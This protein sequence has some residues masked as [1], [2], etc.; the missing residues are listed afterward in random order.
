MTGVQRGALI[1]IC[2]MSFAPGLLVQFHADRGPDLVAGRAYAVHGVPA[3]GRG[4]RNAK[5][6]MEILPKPYLDI[7]TAFA[8][9][10]ELLG[11]A[12]PF[13]LWMITRTSGN[14]WIVLQSRDRAYDVSAGKVFKWTDS[15]CSRMVKGLGP[16]Y[17]PSSEEIPAYRDAPI[18]KQVHIGSYLGT[19]IRMADGSLFGTLCAISPQPKELPELTPFQHKLVEAV[20]RTLATLIENK[21]KADSL[22]RELD[23][24]QEVSLT[25][26]LTGLA[27]RRG[28]ATALGL[29]EARSGQLGGNAAIFMI[30]LDGLKAVNDTLGHAAGDA[31][32]VKTAAVLRRMVR[33]SDTVARLGGDEFGILLAG[34]EG[35]EIEDFATRLREVLEAADVQASI[36]HT[37]RRE[38]GSLEAA[39]AA[40]D[41]LM[42][43]QKQ[44]RKGAAIPGR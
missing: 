18:G 5:A 20:T 30:D 2:R 1:R 28:W 43:A 39:S 35:L 24:E 21:M 7:R 6:M 12:I 3:G 32:I 19:P 9:Y 38:A 17:A 33:G 8:A 10:L 22:L 4:N 14:D 15:F 41:R 29:E 44:A 31:L 23:R 42:Y 25:D 37:L 40:A 11:E 13:D 34:C 26:P 27:N 16:N 36:G